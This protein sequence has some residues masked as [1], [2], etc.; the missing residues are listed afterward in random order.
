MSHAFTL[1]AWIGAAS[2][3]VKL[4]DNNHLVGVGMEGF[5][6]ISTPDRLPD[7]YNAPYWTTVGN[8]NNPAPYAPICEGQDFMANHDLEVK[9]GT[10]CW[11]QECTNVHSH[12]S[13]S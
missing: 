13:D 4:L 12:G 9:L 11:L 6:G 1:Q 10:D 3:Y 2:R 8:G 5:Y 7:N